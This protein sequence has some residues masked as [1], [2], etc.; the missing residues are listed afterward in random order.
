[1][2][3]SLSANHQNYFDGIKSGH[4]AYSHY[5]RKFCLMTQFGVHYYQTGDVIR[6]DIYGENRGTF[7]GIE[8]AFML[9][10]VEK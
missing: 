1:M 10:Q 4:F 5:V 7:Y 8:N 2:H 9:L 3:T 6:T